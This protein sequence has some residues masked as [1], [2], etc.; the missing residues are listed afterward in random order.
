MQFHD[1]GGYGST[2]TLDSL[3]NDAANSIVVDSPGFVNII[4]EFRDSID[5]DPSS[6]EVMRTAAND[7]Q[8]EIF[9]TSYQFP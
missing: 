3:G 4:G 7:Y 1:D 9:I 8:K 2:I 5:F 6:G